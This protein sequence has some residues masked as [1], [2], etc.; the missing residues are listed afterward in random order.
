M[1]LTPTLSNAAA[2]AAALLLAPTGAMTA[3]EN[4]TYDLRMRIHADPASA[5]PDIVLV[6]INDSSLT[7]VE[8]VFG[9]WPWPRAVQLRGIGGNRNRSYAAG[10]YSLTGV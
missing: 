2:T 10:R 8:P 3:L 6:D 7:A 9:R 1:A 4:S 5:R